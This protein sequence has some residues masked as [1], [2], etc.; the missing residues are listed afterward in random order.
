MEETPTFTRI[1]PI[2]P[3]NGCD[4]HLGIGK[5]VY[6]GEN[7]DIAYADVWCQNEECSFTACAQFALVDL[8]HTDADSPVSLVCTEQIEPREAR[9]QR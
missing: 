8:L 4:A 5:P 9:Y 3:R 6:A 2:C 7:T 1:E